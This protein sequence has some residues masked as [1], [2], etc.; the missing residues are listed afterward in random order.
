MPAGPTLDVS[1][2][3]NLFDNQQDV[4][5]FLPDGRSV[6]TT[7]L[8]EEVDTVQVELGDG[9]L[10]FR[11]YCTWHLFRNRLN[12]LVPHINSYILDPY[13]QKWF[14]GSCNQQTWGTRWRL[15]CEMEAGKPQYQLWLPQKPTPQPTT[16]SPM[17]WGKTP[18][19]QAPAILYATPNGDRN[20]CVLYWSK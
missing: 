7:G 18:D 11:Q 15:V 4:T 10:G 5:L 19:G 9:A 13:G 12:G 14:V 1:E 2:D 17:A 8:Q 3:Y 20:A 16:G 6:V